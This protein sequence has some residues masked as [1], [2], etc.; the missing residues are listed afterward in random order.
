[1][2]LLLASANVLATLELASAIRSISS[3]GDN[4]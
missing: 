1:V 4:T 2:E 3:P